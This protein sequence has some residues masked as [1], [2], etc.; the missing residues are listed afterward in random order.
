MSTSRIVAR[1]T[2]RLLTGLLAAKAIDFGFYLYLARALGVEQ[3]G[4]YTFAISFTLLFSVVADFGVQTL[5]TREA[6]RQ[7]ERVRALLREAIG[8][9]AWLALATVALSTLV[10]WATGVPAGTVLL[11]AV[12]AVSML[13]NSAAM[14]FENLLKSGGRAGLAGASVAAQSVTALGVGAALILSGLGVTG[15]A[16]AS[17][18]AA[19]VHLAAAVAWSRDQWRGAPESSAQPR[20][21][22]SGWTLLRESA[23]L[24]VSWVFIAVYFRIDSVILRFMRGESAVGLYGGIYRYFEAFVLLSAAYRSVL[25]PIMARA[26]DGPAQSLGVLCRKSLRLHLMFTIAVAVLFSFEAH[27]IVALTLGK[28]YLPAAPGLAVLIWALPGAFMADT[29]LHLLAAQ[30]RQG[31]VARA[32]GWVAAFN[33]VANLLLIP[34]L[35]LMGAAITTVASE[36]L[37]FVLMYT[38]FRRSVPGIGL[39]QVARAPIVAGAAAAGAF[40]LARQLH[41]EGVGGLAIGCGMALASYFGV[42]VALGALGKSELELFRE[43]LP[44][45]LRAAIGRAERPAAGR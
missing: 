25:Y 44:A 12:F 28:D 13:L 36:A 10:A 27:D 39:V 45:P 42:L 18:A 37:S 7:P 3:F 35:S 40:L 8:V 9:K 6:S 21:W 34:S 2:I 20:V 23:P 19:V 17:L 24:A 1:G 4:R 29:L 26:A 32:M 14:L 16:I 33:V 15:A 38:S 30:K 11:V 41:L 5:F 22:A 31:T 43:I